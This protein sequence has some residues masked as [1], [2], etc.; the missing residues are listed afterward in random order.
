VFTKLFFPIL[1]IGS[2]AWPAGT[3]KKENANLKPLTETTAKYREA[4]LVQMSVKKTIKLEVTGK[5]TQQ[6]GKISLSAG[7]FR[8]ESS[9]PE[10][11]LVVFDGK[12]LWNEQQPSSDFGGEKPQVT[13]AK[14]SD[15]N[16]SQTLLATLL[17]KDPITK[18]FKVLNGKKNAG[19]MVYEME[20]I[21]SEPPMKTLTLKIDTEANIISEI[22]FKDDVGNLTTMKFS[23]TQFKDKLDKKLFEYH[24]PKGVSATEI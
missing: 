5:E 20:P 18:Y 7:L 24:V 16:K 2:L 21:S 13:K 14:L 8:L 3:S 9:E 17:T 12:N 15:K 22:S 10:K 11:S 1:F 6:D 23:N 19:F 4:K